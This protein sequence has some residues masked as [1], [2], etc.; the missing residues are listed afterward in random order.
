MTRRVP[1]TLILDDSGPLNT[2]FMHGRGRPVFEGVK[3]VRDVPVSF[4]ERFV[5]ETKRLGMKGKFTLLPNP[6]CA[7]RIDEG[8]PGYPEEELTRFLDIVREQIVPDWD[9][10]PEILTHWMALD[11]STGKWLDMKE[12]AWAELQDADSLTAY[13]VYALE[14]LKNVDIPANGITSPWC[15]ARG[16]EEA[17][18]EAVGRSLAEVFGVKQAW[19]FLHQSSKVEEDW[20]RIMRRDVEAG[21][22]VVSIVSGVED[23]YWEAQYSNDPETARAGIREKVEGAL[24]GDGKRGRIVEL[25]EAGQPVVLLTHWQSIFG[26]GHGVGLD[27]LVEVIGRL[28]EVYGDRIEWVRPSEI[29]KRALTENTTKD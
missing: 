1:V 10:T 2:M 13:F 25:I 23:V 14:I 17:H 21:T 15:F 18:A 16:V 4:L 19:Y 26:N 22:A 12:D 20:A 11:L 7:G 24:S 5:T 29:A 6:I 9:I 27:A 8:I 28:N 3:L